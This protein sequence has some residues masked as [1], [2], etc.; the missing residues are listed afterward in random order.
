MKIWKL[1]AGI[2]SIILL[3]WSV[4]LFNYTRYAIKESDFIKN[5][6]VN[7][8]ISKKLRNLC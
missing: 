2:L 7:D 6:Y 5:N 4:G 1:V 8:S 3:L